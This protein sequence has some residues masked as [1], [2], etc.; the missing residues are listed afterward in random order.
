MDKIAMIRESHAQKHA[1]VILEHAF[2][3]VSMYEHILGV[4]TS[5]MHSTYETLTGTIL[6][7]AQALDPRN[8]V[9][10]CPQTTRPRKFLCLW[11]HYPTS[12]AIHNCH[13]GKHPRPNSPW[14]VPRKRHRIQA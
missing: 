3:T 10:C 13:P 14:Q 6:A 7:F 12:S 4:N 2:T 1:R 11:H 8:R 5:H 9:R